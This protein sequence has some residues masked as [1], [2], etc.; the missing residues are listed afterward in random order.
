MYSNIMNMH[1]NS[2]LMLLIYLS[3]IMC[4]FEFLKII[5]QNN[6]VNPLHNSY[7]FSNIYFIEKLKDLASINLSKKMIATGIP[8]HVSILKE[9]I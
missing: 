7:I 3:S 9:L 4:H 2:L 5:I 1:K 8:H 6:L